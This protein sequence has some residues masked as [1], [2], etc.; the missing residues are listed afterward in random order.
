MGAQQI[1]ACS[2]KPHELSFLPETH[3][4]GV[5]CPRGCPLIFTCV[6]WHV[7]AYTNIHTQTK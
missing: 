4:A 5:R 1:K 6:L 7:L 3:V 2:D